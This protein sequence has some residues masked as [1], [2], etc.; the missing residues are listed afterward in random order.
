MFSVHISD[1][2]PRKKCGQILGRELRALSNWGKVNLSNVAKPLMVHVMHLRF[3][4]IMY[5]VLARVTSRLHYTTKH[6]N[7]HAV[8]VNPTVVSCL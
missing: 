1:G 8:C 2:V 6:I 3:P 7:L 5:N 4:N